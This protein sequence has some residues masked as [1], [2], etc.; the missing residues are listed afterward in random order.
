MLISSTPREVRDSIK[1]SALSDIF[2]TDKN[3]LKRK[4][5]ALIDKANQ[6]E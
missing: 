5:N 4:L 1:L 6:K 2:L 3:K